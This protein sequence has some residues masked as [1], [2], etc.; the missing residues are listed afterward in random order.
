MKGINSTDDDGPLLIN[1]S[2]YS[3]FK[4]DNLTYISN[5][6][7]DSLL[8]DDIMIEQEEWGW[9]YSRYSKN[10][11]LW[12]RSLHSISYIF[13]CFCFV[14]SISLSKLRNLTYSNTPFTIDPYFKLAIWVIILFLGFPF[15]RVLY[16]N[17][18][19][20]INLLSRNINFLYLPVYFLISLLF[21]HRAVPG[22]NYSLV[23]EDITIL[24][25]M[26]FVLV[27]YAKVKYQDDGRYKVGIAEFIGVQ[28]HFSALVAML[29]VEACEGLFKTLGFYMDSNS[30]DQL[31]FGWANENWTILVMTLT[32]W[33]GSLSLYLYKDVFYAGVL[34]IV[35]TGIYS[36]QKRLLCPEN[37]GNCSKSVA[38]TALTLGILLM[39]FILITVI[40]YPKLVMYSVR[41]K[42]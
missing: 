42:S 15:I 11:V 9:L 25:S 27:I 18:V 23:T 8:V 19:S 40:T 6:S 35:Y 32:F 31:L 2:A 22:Y 17:S 30:N 28:I 5:S 26:C 12:L 13:Q 20:S 34:S 21:I 41:K 4:S 37:Q 3:V 36:I 16:S 7:G 38:V 1:S 14:I 39:F 24:V 33:T 29:L 10:K